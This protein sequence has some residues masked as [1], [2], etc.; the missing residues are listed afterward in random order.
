MCAKEK[1]SRAVRRGPKTRVQIVDQW[2]ARWPEVLKLIERLGHRQILRLDEDGWLS[3]RQSVV[4]A[5]VDGEP[6][7]HLCFHVDPVGQGRVEAQLDAVGFGS[8]QASRLLS[9]LLAD[10]AAR[11]ARKLN[12]AAF[13]GLRKDGGF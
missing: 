5:F 4:V 12:C 2:N 6:A 1:K 13:N 11:H 10:A 9:K 7:A 8:A 3:A